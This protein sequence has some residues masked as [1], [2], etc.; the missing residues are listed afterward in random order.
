MSN[1][2][3]PL[4]I[5]ESLAFAII[6]DL[7]STLSEESDRDKALLICSTVYEKFFSKKANLRRT[8]IKKKKE[9]KTKKDGDLKIEPTGKE[10]KIQIKW[11]SHPT[12]E[13][14]KYTKDIVFEDGCFPLFSV[15]QDKVIAAASQNSSRVLTENDRGILSS[16]SLAF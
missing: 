13:D 6:C 3:F 15:S 12:K 10:H 1:D 9:K 8:P 4:S 16:R 7:Q 2:N 11:H 14:L 5:I